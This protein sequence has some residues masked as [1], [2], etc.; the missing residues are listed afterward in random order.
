MGALISKFSDFPPMLT[1]TGGYGRFIASSQWQALSVE[2]VGKLNVVFDRVTPQFGSIGV[3][4]RRL[5]RRSGKGFGSVDLERIS[6]GIAFTSRGSN[7]E[8]GLGAELAL[9]ILTF[10][11]RGV[12]V[13][14]DAYVFEPTNMTGPETFLVVGLG[15]VH[16]P[17]TGMGRSV[18]IVR[19]V[20]TPPAS[21][22]GKAC[23]QLGAYD[24]TL[25]KERADAVQV[26]NAGDVAACEVARARVVALGDARAACARGDEVSPPAE[27]IDALS[28]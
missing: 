16:L 4:L 7:L 11:G 14:I 28:P 1:A 5:G 18:P 8:V 6:T 21:T 19:Q 9:G 25:R 2:A 10:G 23:P 15:Y 20:R 27:V 24:E 12:G 13:T 22:P 26:C 17:V 3:G